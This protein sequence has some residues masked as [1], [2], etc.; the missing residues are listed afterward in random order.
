MKLK[1]EEICEITTFTWSVPLLQLFKVINIYNKIF[2][3]F[4]YFVMTSQGNHGNYCLLSTIFYFYYWALP[5]SNLKFLALANYELWPAG[6]K[7]PIPG[8][9]SSKKPR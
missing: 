5:P 7:L 8:Y 4:L 6:K 2:Q 9:K 1:I 3:N